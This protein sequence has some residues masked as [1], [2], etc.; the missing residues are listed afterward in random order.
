MN[1]AG[2]ISAVGLQEE[3]IACPQCGSTSRV[4]RG[5]CLNCLLYRGLGD[6][7]YDNETLENVLDAVEVRDVDWHLGNY[8]ILEEIG[9]GAGGHSERHVERHLGNY[10]SLEK[11][12]H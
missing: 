9:R 2:T 11:I 6:E 10:R 1:S 8:Q 7:T 12:R 5:L 4:G 3:P